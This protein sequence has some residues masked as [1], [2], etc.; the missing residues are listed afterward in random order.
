MSLTADEVIKIAHLAR[1]GIDGRDVPHYAE[2]LSGML[3]LMAEM[4]A[5]DTGNVAPMAHP[6]DL[7][8][9]LRADQVSE[10]NQREKFQ[11]IAPQV[12]AGLY[13]VPKVIE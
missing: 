9:R 10:S 4:G 6:L 5:V 11:A 3:D 12:E 7:R 13:L 8:Q 1:L 2:D